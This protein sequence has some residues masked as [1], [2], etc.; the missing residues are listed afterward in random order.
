M[1][2]LLSL[3]GLTALLL[4]GCSFKLLPPLVAIDSSVDNTVDCTTRETLNFYHLFPRGDSGYPMINGIISAFNASEAAAELEVCIKGN[5]VNFW[6]YWSRVDNS[7]SGNTAPDIFLHTLDD[8]VFRARN[9]KLLNIDEMVA[10]DLAASRDTLIPDDVFYPLQLAA[11]SYEGNLY[12]LPWS[13]TVRAVYYNKSLWNDVG[14]S[15][16]DIPT[17]WEELKTISAQMITTKEDGNYDTIGFDPFSGEGYFQ[18]WVWSNGLDVW[19]VVDGVYQ[20]HF[21]DADI[22]NTLSYLQSFPARADR[23]KLQDFFSQFSVT[24]QDPFVSGKVGMILGTEGLHFSLKAAEVP[25]DYGVFVIPYGPDNVNET[26]VNWSSSFSLELFDNH[27]REGMTLEL[28]DRR[29]QGTWEFAKFLYSHDV[30]QQLFDNAPFLLSHR[31]YLSEFSA[32][33]PILVDLA[34]SIPFAIEKLYVP[35]A[36]KWHSD[37]HGQLQSFYNGS[38]TAQEVLDETQAAI[39]AKIDLYCTTNADGWGC[40]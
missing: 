24:G 18:Q 7:I 38:K 34:Q 13:T 19:D 29:N 40:E 16:D 37:L 1:K 5:G 4:A 23:D 25:F 8:S 21:N 26:P 33:D 32:S 20:P 15:E 28:G 14:L 3:G 12:A 39:S 22:V 11:G 36:P 9:G 31:A 35:M 2:R 17:T 27:N 10:A 6:D 30:Q